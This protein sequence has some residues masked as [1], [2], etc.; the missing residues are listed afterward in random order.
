MFQAPTLLGDPFSDTPAFPASEMEVEPAPP[1]HGTALNGLDLRWLLLFT[2]SNDSL[3]PPATCKRISELFRNQPAGEAGLWT[4]S[5]SES[6]D[7]EKELRTFVNLLSFLKEESR[8]SPSRRLLPPLPSS[9]MSKTKK[10]AGGGE[11]GGASAD[12]LLLRAPSFCVRRFISAMFVSSSVSLHLIQHSKLNQSELWLRSR[13][14]KN[15]T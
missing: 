1:K 10:T 7:Q 12:A 13:W 11:S 6:G 8:R 4:C 9:R 15:P 2:Y 14:R 3:V 5:C